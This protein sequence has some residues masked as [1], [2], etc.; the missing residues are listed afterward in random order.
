MS[1]NAQPQWIWTPEK[2]AER[3]AFVRFRKVFQ[4]NG[5]RT[6][7]RVTADSVYVLFVNGQ[8]VGQGPIRSWPFKRKYDTYDIT[9]YLQPGKNVLAVRVQHYGVGTFQYNCGPAGLWVRLQTGDVTLVSGPD[10]KTSIDP[11]FA[12]LT[13]RIS[14]QQAYEEQYDARRADGWQHVDYD[15][16]A[17]A[18]AVPV[19]APELAAAQLVPRD[20]PHLTL[21]PVQPKRFVSADAVRSIQRIWSFEV[22][23]L[24][25]PADRSANSWFASAYLATQIWS[26]RRVACRLHRPHHHS[27]AYKLNGQLT[28]DEHV[29][30]EPGWNQVLFPYKG[31]QHRSHFVLCVDCDEPLKFASKGEAGGSPW[32]VIGPFALSEDER[33]RAETYKDTS[34]LIC[35]PLAA[36]ATAE[37]AGRVWEDG[38]V[39]PWV[40][41]PYFQ[42]VP[43]DLLVPVDVFAQSYTDKPTGAAVRVERPEALLSKNQEWTTVHPPADGSDARILLDYGTEVVGFHRFVVD[44][45]AGTI[46]DFHNFE[47]IQADGRF[48]FAEGMNNSFRYVCKEGYQTYQTHVRRG[49]RYTYVTIRNARGP[50]R[51]RN[52][53]VLYNSYPQARRGS[54]HS[55]DAL[56]N[57]IWEV[58]ADTLRACAEDTYTD[59][60]SYEQTLWVGDARN[61]ALIDWVINGDPRLWYRCLELA[62][63]SLHRSPLVESNVPSGWQNIIPAWAFLWMR[64]CREYLLFT[65]DTEGSRRLLDFVRRNVDGMRS[66]INDAGLFEIQAWNFFDWAAMDTPH[67]GV[68]THQN[69]LAVLA[70]KECAELAEWLGASEL[71]RDWRALAGDLAAAINDHLWNEEKGAYTDAL[72]GTEQSSVFSQQTQTVAYISGVAQGERAERCRAVMEEPPEDFVKAGSPFF[73]FFLLEAIQQEGKDQLFLD[74]L[75]RDWGFMIDMGATTFWEMWSRRGGRLTR[76]HCHGWSA[77]PTFFLS[78]HVLGVRPVAPGFA[79]AVVEPHPG[80]LAWCRGTVPTPHGP[81]TVQW[82]RSHDGMHIAVTAPDTVDLEVVPPQPGAR[83][84]VNGRIVG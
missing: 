15:D 57:R 10:W 25:H 19:D 13:P 61:E 11:A 55:A 79:K 7:I 74:I 82:R 39:A 5:E 69:C 35:E 49:F 30:L 66:H 4:W 48:C 1:A 63:E 75:R 46:L 32:A 73:E 77:A 27:G 16:S 22:K 44:A 51:F 21:E 52:V 54:F 37:Q 2:T 56:L 76:S 59:C 26:P 45:P 36:G 42:E 29:E 62:G 78:T 68:V 8:Y 6:D 20:I 3:N 9:P 53:E 31:P 50:V 17:W 72:R 28:R 33:R 60:P 18:D 43:A 40:D 14:I 81:I 23:P 38:T 64:S 58:G 34:I 70:L 71:A 67:V 41:E 47:F 12:T 65:G 80:D 84:E 83:V 24:L